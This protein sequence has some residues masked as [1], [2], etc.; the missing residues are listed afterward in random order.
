MCLK[1]ILHAAV[2]C[3]QSAGF[4]ADPQQDFLH[5]RA[6]NIGVWEERLPLLCAE[7]L[8]CVGDL[9]LVGY[10]KATKTH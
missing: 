1:D 9:F 8:G 2:Q 3:R 4:G 10:S 6:V 5:F 7:E